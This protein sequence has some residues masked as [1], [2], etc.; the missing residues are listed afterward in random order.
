MCSSPG[1]AINYSS[2]GRWFGDSGKWLERQVNDYQDSSWEQTRRKIEDPLN[3]FASTRD[4][5]GGNVKANRRERQA[6]VAREIALTPN[7]APLAPEP[8]AM[9]VNPATEL[10]DRRRRAIML[11]RSNLSQPGPGANI[12]LG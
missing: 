1:G 5:L 11:A 4:S 12:P 7:P 3:L 10:R 2:I 8:T 9:L 6:E